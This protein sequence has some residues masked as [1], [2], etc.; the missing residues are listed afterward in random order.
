[1][2]NKIQKINYIFAIIIFAG[3]LMGFISKGSIISLI[4]SLIFALL[5]A[6]ANYRLPVSKKS[7]YTFILITLALII[8][9]FW[10][11]FAFGAIMPALPIIILSSI[12]LGLNAF[13]SKQQ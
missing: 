6:L 10:R 5:L 9:F 7:H 1:M 8:L 4:A 13:I 2:L 12:I 3:G 11:L